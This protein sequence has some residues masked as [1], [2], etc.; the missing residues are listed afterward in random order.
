MMRKYIFF[1]LLGVIPAFS[2]SLSY[3]AFV[4]T[5][6]STVLSTEEFVITYKISQIEGKLYVGF[7][8]NMA[9]TVVGN[10]RWEVIVPKGQSRRIEFR[11]R[12]KEDF[13]K[14]YPMESLSFGVTISRIPFKAEIN[15]TENMTMGS[16]ILRDYSKLRQDFLEAKKKTSQKTVQDS[17]VIKRQ[18]QLMRPPNP[19]KSDTTQIPDYSPLLKKKG[20]DSSAAHGTNLVARK[21]TSEQS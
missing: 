16:V 1:F 13:L 8:S 10:D 19:L 21:N 7:V 11:V 2:Q 6:K 4:T 12:C 17:V 5:S 3:K 15:T 14:N 18:S 9:L 20:K